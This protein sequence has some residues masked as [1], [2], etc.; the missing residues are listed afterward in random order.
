[1]EKGEILTMDRRTELAHPEDG[2]PRSISDGGV[3]EM[4]RGAE[5]LRRV[6]PC[7]DQTGAASRWGRIVP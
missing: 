7:E 1:M 6:V 5:R 3:N 4:R 2:M